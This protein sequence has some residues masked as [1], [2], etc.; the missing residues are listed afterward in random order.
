M[1]C[2]LVLLAY[3]T[4]ASAEQHYVR[5]GVDDGLPNATIYSIKQDSTGFLWLGSTNSGL[6][7]YDG[8]RFVEFAVL[9]TAELRHH[10]TPDVGVVLIDNADNIWAGTWGLG[11][12]RLDAQTGELTRYTRENGLAGNQIQSLLQ[13]AN[14]NIWVGTTSGLSRVDT[15]FQIT[16]IGQV[17]S[18]QALADQR[19]WSLSQTHDGAVWVGTSAGLHSW[20]PDKGL[21]QVYQLVNH[22]DD[23]VSGNFSRD[24]EIRAVYAL[25]QQLWVGSRQ[26]LFLFN[27]QRLQFERVPLALYGE[28]EPL[29]NILSFDY[30]T[31]EL[32][33]GSYSGLYRVSP[34]HQ[35]GHGVKKAELGNVNVRSILQDNSGVLWVGSRESGLF[36]SILSSKAFD[37]ISAFSTALGAQKTFSVTAIF[38]QPDAL[39]LGSSNGIYR[40][41]LPTGDF[42]F[43]STGSR[44]N[45]IAATP[46]NEL[47]IASDTGLLK[48]NGTAKLIKTDEP[49]ELANV[50]NRNVRDLHIDAAG[51][52]Y[53]GMWGEGVI[54]WQPERQ[55]T[56]RW[57]MQ[58]SDNM[59]GNAVQQLLVGSSQQLWV[60]TRYSG[61][62]QID[63]ATDHI[64]QHTAGAT[65]GIKLPHNDIHCV[66]EHAAVLAVC[67]R[68][69]LLL[70][71]LTTAE[72]QLLTTQDSLPDNDILGVLQQDQQLWVMTPKGLALR[73]AG[74]QHFIHYNRNDGMV[75]SELNTNAVFADDSGILF[76][77]I[78]GLIVVKPDQ[79]QSNQKVPEPVLSALVIDYQQLQIKPHKQPWEIINLSADQHTMN[80]EFSALDYQDPQRNQFQYQLEGIDKSWVIANERNSAFYAN[81]P[82]GTY[83]LWLKASNN[84]GV[85]SEPVKVATLN[86][87]PHWWQQ[88][89]VMYSLIALVSL[90]L[91]LM[92]QYRLRH[93]RQINRLLQA[94]VENKVKAQTVLETRVAERTRAL[95]ESSVTL[96]LRTRQLERSL[97][98]LAKTNQDLKLLDKLKDEFIATVS[99][100][101]RTPLTAIRGAIG[102][103]TQKVV[104]ADSA[105]YQDMLQTAQAN[106]ERLA[107]LINDLLD[108]QKFAAGTF[109]LNI[110]RL[111]ITA[112]TRHAVNAMQPYASRYQVE[113]QLASEPEQPLWVEADALR[114]R[115]VIDNLISNAVKFSAAQ[116]VVIVRLVELQQSIRFEVEDFG[117][118]IPA[119]FQKH[120]FGKFSQADASDSRAKEGTGLGLAI[121]KKII[122][123]HHGQI[124]F[125]SSAGQGTVFWFKLARQHEPVLTG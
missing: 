8:Y 9:T 85:F 35:A 41:T 25:G 30:S 64:T 23:S 80:F 59:V 61:L 86:V 123:N 99:H 48:Y 78:A 121:C 107:H 82:V 38:K 73:L 70:V 7:R 60:A 32:L 2:L 108:L 4:G 89:W 46:Q 50:V 91:W 12:S 71:N 81:L 106:S 57:L 47:Y 1:R 68:E 117:S 112:L 45:A 55:H 115:Q 11:L 20:Q 31:A 44:V 116:G 42:Q 24:N 72:Q 114:L 102:L 87:M 49:F 28:P 66:S 6:L 94:A 111:D 122:E 84:H 37:N 43:F 10:Q 19:I 103:I 96:S 18:E 119:E 95:E 51:R 36:R 83:P 3:C 29:I 79:L 90:L 69:G 97:D 101:L 39:W 120:I 54:A 75:S 76:G 100:E 26:G 113:L 14:G 5:I 40:I 52:F 63:L 104:T 16:N 110:T 22:K 58:L 88:S 15:Q 62:F 77:A 118:G 67:T 13:D 34:D 92:H 21:S 74:Q 27:R 125:T 17:G 124:G 56:K 93:V 109:T 33:A 65:S 53:L 98:E 105:L